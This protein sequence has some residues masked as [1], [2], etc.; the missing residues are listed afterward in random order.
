VRQPWRISRIVVWKSS[1]I[2]SVATPPI[3]S[4]AWRLISAAEPHQ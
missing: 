3:S 2:V 1:A 4:S